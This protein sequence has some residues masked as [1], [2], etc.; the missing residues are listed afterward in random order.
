M[1]NV[2]K[3]VIST[4]QHVLITNT[5]AKPLSFHQ[6]VWSLNLLIAYASRVLTET[7]SCYTQI[8]KEML[9]FSPW[10]SLMTTPLVERQRFSVT[11]SHWNQFLGRLCIV[12]PKHSLGI[13]I[14]TEV[15]LVGE[16]GEGKQDVLCRH[17]FK[18]VSPSW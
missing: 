5:A 4:H 17:P 12:P 6:N 1:R 13:I 10:R 3:L 11:T 2:K 9:F 7:E 8:E 16:V 15:R 14:R 18:S